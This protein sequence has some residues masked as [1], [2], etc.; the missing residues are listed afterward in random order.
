MNKDIYEVEKEDYVGFLSQIKPNS[1]EKQVIENPNCTI[2]N[3][4]SKLT[5]KLLCSHEI[6]QDDKKEY[7]Y[8]YKMPDDQERCEPPRIKKLHLETRE[9]VQAFFDIISKLQKND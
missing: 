2:F 7:Y 3:F 1:L 5:N 6:Y 4:N 8:I 9:E